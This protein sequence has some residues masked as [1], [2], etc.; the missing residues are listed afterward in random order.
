MYSLILKNSEASKKAWITRRAGKLN[1]PANDPKVFKR[2]LNSIAKNT[3][4]NDHGLALATG[5]KLLGMVEEAKA[6]MKVR[7][8]HFKL[9]GLSGELYDARN[10]LSKKIF[11]YAEKVL[12]KDKLKQF[13]DAF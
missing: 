7:A 2:G 10:A 3:D 5:A 11:D 9:G 12:P 8:K 4:R 13:T 6:V 1:L